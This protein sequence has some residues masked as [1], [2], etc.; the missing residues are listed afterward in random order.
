MNN[1]GEI[2]S[3]LKEIQEGVD[4]GWYLVQDYVYDPYIIANRKIN[5]RY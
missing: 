1:F 2:D 4:N 3:D 5:F